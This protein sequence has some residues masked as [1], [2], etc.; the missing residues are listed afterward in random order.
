M[1]QTRQIADEMTVLIRQLVM[2]GQLVMASKVLEVYF[3]RNWKVSKEVAAYFMR[4]YFEKH[5]ADQVR[6]F[7]Q[8]IARQGGE[9][10]A[11]NAGT[12]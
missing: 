5:Y 10:I 3:M 8:R 4:K 9:V 1:K 11:K 12:A 2:N 6:K 7:R